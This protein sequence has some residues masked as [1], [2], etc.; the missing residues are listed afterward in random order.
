[1]KFSEEMNTMM[2]SKKKIV[3]L[4]VATLSLL[5]LGAAG[6]A[7]KHFMLA[8]VARPEVKMQLSGAVERDSGLVAFEKTT[9]VNRG[10]ILDWT[11]TS[12]NSGNADARDYKVVGHI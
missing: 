6:F 11:I 5:V 3:A 9:V 10:E 7:Q 1:V 2:K 8:N 4:F 12:E